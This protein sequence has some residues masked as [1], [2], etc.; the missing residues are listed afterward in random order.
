MCLAKELKTTKSQTTVDENPKYE[1]D[2]VI[3]DFHNE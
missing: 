3:E 1:D 2:F